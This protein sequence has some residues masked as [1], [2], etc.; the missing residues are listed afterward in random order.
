MEDDKLLQAAQVE[1][2]RSNRDQQPLD[3]LCTKQ[4]LD[5]EVEWFEKKLTELLN[6]HAKITQITSYSKRWWN[7]EVAE[8]RSTLAKDK[9][10]F[11]RNEDLKEEFKQA[12][13]RYYRT[14]K[15]AKRECWQNFL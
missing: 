8:V 13:N 10:R 6:N 3:L 15:K 7:K 9:R 2:K 12:R 14:I 11:G 5:K 4:D 1:W